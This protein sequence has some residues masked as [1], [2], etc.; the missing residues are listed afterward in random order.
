MKSTMNVRFLKLH[1]IVA[2]FP[3]LG[4]LQTTSVSA[5]QPIAHP[6]H[7]HS[8]AEPAANN[9]L[10]PT[11]E[12]PVQTMPRQ[13]ARPVQATMAGYAPGCG[14]NACNLPTQPQVAKGRCQPC[15]VA[16]DCAD[17]CGG[18]RQSWHDLHRYDLQPLAQGEYLGP[19]RL[20]STLSYRIRVGDELRFVYVLSRAVL[21]DTFPLQ[22]GDELQ[23]SS[24]TDDKVRLGDVMQGRGVVI[25]PDGMLYLRLIGPV[26]AAGLTIPQLRTNLEK[27]YKDL[28]RN[29]AI[30]VIPIKTNTLLEELRSAVIAR[31]GLSGQTF[32]DRV[33]PDGTVR[34]PKLGPICVQ[35]M[36]LD[37]L[38]R[39][40]NLRYRELVSGLEV[41][42]VLGTEA[43]HFIFVYG[44]VGQPGRYELLGPTTVTQGLALAQGAIPG[45]NTREIVIFRRAEDWRLI[46][47]RVDIRGVQLGK[48]PSP[49][50]EIWLRDSDLIIVPPTPI[51]RFDNFVRQVFT[52]GIYGVLPFAQVGSGFNPNSFRP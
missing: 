35:G 26:R 46:A 29:P 40:V 39:E 6:P 48:A 18:E 22:V 17:N 11:A 31:V 16:I 50:D 27:A 42:P 9:R 21:A 5:Q 33:H 25:Q 14:F 36:T 20:P 24:L 49:A 7:G 30:D 32:T 47:T 28:I 52:E 19:I 13:P 43:Q 8:P 34:L 37:E 4:T 3:L 51:R 2:L 45:A 23:I 15:T 44:Q 12:P 10:A 41:E 1:L 38:K